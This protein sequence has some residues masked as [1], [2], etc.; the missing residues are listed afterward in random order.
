MNIAT[1]L[2]REASQLASQMKDRSQAIHRE[3]LIVKTRLDALQLE[4]HEVD[5]ALRRSQNF[6]SEVNGIYQCPHCWVQREH[7]SKLIPVASNDGNDVFKCS[8]CGYQGSF[9]PES[10]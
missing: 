6:T 3:L 4:I 7:R 2:Q 8:E 10:Y 9:A 5:N 1:D